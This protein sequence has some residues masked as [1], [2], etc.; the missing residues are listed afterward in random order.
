MGEE[1]F[2]FDMKTVFVYIVFKAFQ[3]AQTTPKQ[4][5]SATN[6]PV[7]KIAKKNSLRECVFLIRHSKYSAKLSKIRCTTDFFWRFCSLGTVWEQ[8]KFAL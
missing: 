6:Y 3:A 1:S 2:K 8:F 5:F 7:G 4:S